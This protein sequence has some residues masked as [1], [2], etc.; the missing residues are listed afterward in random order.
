M[1]TPPGFKAVVCGS[2]EESM[3]GRREHSSTNSSERISERLRDQVADRHIH[4]Y[5]EDAW[6]LVN[7]SMF[8]CLSVAEWTAPSVGA[9]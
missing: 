9:P 3:R 8:I 2:G 1:D 7:G 6:H 4:M 5:K